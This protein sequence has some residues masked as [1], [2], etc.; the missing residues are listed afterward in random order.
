MTILLQSLVFGIL[1]GG[2][3]ALASSGLALIFGVM[4]IVNLAHGSLLIGAAFL[5]YSLCKATGLDPFATIPVIAAVLFVV[6]WV[7]Y[8]FVIQ[9]AEKGGEV[10]VIVAT[11]AVAM[12]LEGILVLTW[13]T[14]LHSVTPSYVNSSYRLGAI[15]FPKVQ[16]YGFLVAVVLLAALWLLLTRSWLGRALRACAA[17]AVGARLA[18]IEV[19][20]V[21]VLSYALGVA[22]TGAAGAIVAVLAPF[23]TDSGDGWIGLGLAIVVL[24]GLGSLTGA[25]VGAFLFGLA[26]TLTTTYASAAW[27]TAVPYVLILVVLLLRPQ[28]IL[29]TRV[30][31][32]VVAR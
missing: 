2:V 7:L 12:I 24:G 3:Y 11:L 20:R 6:G 18:G 17:N 25:L 32:D 27:A 13:G 15:V 28:G 4:R 14:E 1:A 23:G 10:A 22:A 8:R 21:N 16:V 31:A 19:E 29:G 30:R 5:T 26:E 9:Y